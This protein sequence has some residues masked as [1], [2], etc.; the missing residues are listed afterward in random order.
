MNLAL[1]SGQGI[2]SAINPVLTDGLKRDTQQAPEIE[3][4]ARLRFA[5]FSCLARRRFNAVGSSGYL[6]EPFS[7]GRYFQESPRGFPVSNPF[8]SRAV[9]SSSFGFR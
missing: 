8:D 5:T 7:E 3:A 2:I 6:N 9:F 4:G 1:R